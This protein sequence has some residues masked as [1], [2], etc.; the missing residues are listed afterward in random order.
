MPMTIHE[1]PA[2]DDISRL[3]SNCIDP[4]RELVCVLDGL[5]NEAAFGKVDA[6]SGSSARQYVGD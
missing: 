1:P 4:L 5:C 6:T 3:I 2:Y